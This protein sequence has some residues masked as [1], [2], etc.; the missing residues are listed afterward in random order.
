V[1]VGFKNHICNNLCIYSDGFLDDLRVMSVQELSNRVFQLQTRFDS[2]RQINHLSTLSNYSLTEHQ[3]ARLVGKSLLYQYLPQKMK[4]TMNTVVPIS[5]TQIS[6]IGR[7]Y[8]QDKSFCRSES[9]DIDVWKVYNLFKGATKPSY[10]DTFLD[11][12]VGSL[13]FIS[14]LIDHLNSKRPSWFLTCMINS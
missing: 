13:L 2:D 8:Y 12:N 4:K 10:I 3:F 5:D 14:S 7:D 9:G 11:R 1:F 6:T